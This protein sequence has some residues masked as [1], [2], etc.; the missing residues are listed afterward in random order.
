[1]SKLAWESTEAEH[2]ARLVLLALADDHNGVTGLCC[3]SVKRLMERTR[4]GKT[5][6][7]Q[8]IAEL[9]ASGVIIVDRK[10]GCGSRYRFSFR[11]GP[12]SEPVQELDPSGFRTQPVHIPNP[13]GSDSGPVTGNNRK[14]PEP[15]T[16]KGESGELL[17]LKPA[18]GSWMS[19]FY[20]FWAAYPKKVNKQVAMS[21]WRKLAPDEHITREIIASVNRRKATDEWIKEG[22]KY[23]MAPDRFLRGKR[24]EDQIDAIETRET[25]AARLRSMPGWP[26]HIG[27]M[28][29]TEADKAA[30]ASLLARYKALPE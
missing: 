24:W 6:V 17:R 3:P 29:A 13:T 30:Y 15:P 20:E 19:R 10:T 7:V 21:V 1:M 23:I 22:G 5:V 9:E 12:D 4:L 18:T 26:N 8:A 14:E 28:S 2:G 11:T 27:H 25:I 16:P